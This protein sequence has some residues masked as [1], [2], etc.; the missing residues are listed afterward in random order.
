MSK[1]NGGYMG[2]Q[3]GKLGPAVGRIWRGMNVYAGYQK[4]VK[5]PRTVDQLA[6]RAKFGTLA[7][8][9]RAMRAAT[10]KGL[11]GIKTIWDG[12]NAFMHINWDAVSGATA[13]EVAVSYADL[14]VSRGNLPPVVFGSADFETPLTVK[15]SFSSNEELDGADASDE[16]YML[17]YQAD[18]KQAVLGAPVL[19]S[20]EGIDVLVPASWSGMRV[21]VYGFAVAGGMNEEMKGQTSDSTFIGTGNIG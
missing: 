14:V 17:V 2:Q 18:L 3:V 15:A 6:V 13:A 4:F 21:H 16:V 11:A 8:I 5:N 1:N 12:N 9:S 20:S 7:S 10:K 19:R